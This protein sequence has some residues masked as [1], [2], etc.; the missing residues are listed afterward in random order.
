MEPASTS[1]ANIGKSGFLDKDDRI[2]KSG[3]NSM[4]KNANGDEER[5]DM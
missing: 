1:K 2:N 3:D 4:L 5:N